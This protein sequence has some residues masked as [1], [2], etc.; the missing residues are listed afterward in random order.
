[1]EGKRV[2]AAAA[3]CCLLVVLMLPGQ[4]QQAAAMSRYCKCYRECYTECR[5]EHNP[6]V[7]TLGCGQDCI[8]GGYPPNPPRS[9]PDCG[10][11]CLGSTCGVMANALADIE[12]CLAECSKDGG[13]KIY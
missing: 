11:I 12:A 7:C 5:K 6:Y 3:V 9:N 8:T 13:A 1:M 2:A 4:V 10:G